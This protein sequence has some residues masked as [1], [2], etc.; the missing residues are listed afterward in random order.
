[1][2]KKSHL[3]ASPPT[4]Y[5]TDTICIE[6][7]I[8][9][10]SPSIKKEIIR[11]FSDDK[12]KAY[13]E[14]N[15]LYVLVTF[16]PTTLDIVGIGEEIQQQKDEKLEKVLTFLFW[17]LISIQFITWASSQAETLRNAG[18]FTDLFDPSSG[19]PVSDLLI[20][21]SLFS[22]QHIHDR[23]NHI[24]NDIELIQHFL[25]YPVVQAGSCWII[26]HPKWYTHCYPATM[27][28]TAEPSQIVKAINQLQ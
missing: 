7:S 5:Q 26:S 2:D 13:L 24:M 9:I 22:V 19:C 10:C 18:A 1:M 28:T 6:Y 16:Q 20:S 15:T 12:V 21:Y 3:L 25:P 8:H 11:T 17:I 4:L 23:S 27:I 14:C